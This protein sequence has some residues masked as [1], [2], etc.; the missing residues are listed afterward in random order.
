VKHAGVIEGLILLGY[1]AF[2]E[3]RNWFFGSLKIDWIDSFNLG[4]AKA[5]EQNSRANGIGISFFPWRPTCC[6]L[7]QHLT[8]SVLSL[9][10]TTH[11]KRRRQ[12]LLR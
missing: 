4:K 7:F 5:A 8:L 9:T 6:L 3:L 11:K 2:C 1:A 12:N 10:T